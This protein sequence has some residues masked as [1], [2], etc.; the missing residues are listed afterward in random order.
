MKRATSTLK[1]F[2]LAAMFFCSHASF[3][4]TVAVKDVP[5]RPADVETLDGLIRAFYEVVN[6]KPGDARQ[7]DRDRTL[8]VPWVRFIATATDLAGKVK[9][10]IWTHQQ[11][12]E[13]T[14]PLVQSGFKEWEVSRKTAQYGNIAHID[15]VYAGEAAA[16]D[17]KIERFRGLNSIE[18]YFDGKRWWI[19]SVMWMSESPN[20]PIPKAYLEKH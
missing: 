14:E 5:A 19:S 9:N 8:Y 20:H 6:I 7:W 15:S 3:A 18:A 11:Y 1:L 4:Q 2:L 12:V 17:G 13:A 16:G 10:T